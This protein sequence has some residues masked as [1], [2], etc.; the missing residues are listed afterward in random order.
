MLDTTVDQLIPHIQR[1]AQ[2]QCGT[3]PWR[4]TM[5]QDDSTAIMA[6]TL[7][8]AGWRVSNG[9]PICPTCVLAITETASGLQSAFVHV[10]E[11]ATD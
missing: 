7:H 9:K 3:C 8:V 10:A 6:R 4:C 5:I 11:V 1:I 2:I